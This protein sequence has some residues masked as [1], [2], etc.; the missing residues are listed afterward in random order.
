MYTISTL[1][2]QNKKNPES[3]FMLNISFK[4]KNYNTQLGNGTG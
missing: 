3:I 2:K 4:K 1:K